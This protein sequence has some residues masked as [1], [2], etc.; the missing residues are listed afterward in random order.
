MTRILHEIR[1]AIERNTDPKI[2]RVIVSRRERF[3]IQTEI[4][5]MRGG[6]SP[7]VL[8]WGRSGWVYPTVYIDSIP[9]LV[10]EE[11]SQ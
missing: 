9:I 8:G 4:D 1:E 10:R 11:L 5:I 2:T 6:A 7:V 3:Q